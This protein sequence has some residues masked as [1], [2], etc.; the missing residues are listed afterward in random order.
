MKVTLSNLLLI[1]NQKSKEMSTLRYDVMNNWGAISVLAD[2]YY[3][4]TKEYIVRMAKQDQNFKKNYEDIIDYIE[5]NAGR[6]DSEFG[7]KI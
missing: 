2:D 1:I 7:R 6:D 3:E 5:T 4:K